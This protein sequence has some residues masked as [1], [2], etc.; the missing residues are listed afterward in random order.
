MKAILGCLLLLALATAPAMAGRNASGGMLV[1][2]N[3]SVV[4]SIG[5]DYCGETMPADC[6]EFQ[7]TIHKGPDDAAVIWALA[8][9]CWESSPGVTA[10]RFGVSGEVPQEY[11]AA[12]AP[13]GPGTVENPDATWPAPG[14]GTEVSYATPVYPSWVMKMYWFAAWG[15]TGWSLGTGAYP[16]GDMQAEFVDDS[17]PPV[18]DYC[19]AFGAVRWGSP[20]ANDCT[21]CGPPPPGACCFPDGTCQELLEDECMGAGG[22]WYGP[23]IPCD[24][25]PCVTHL[26]ACCFPDGHCEPMIYGTGQCA[27]E[28]GIGQGIDTYCDP[29]PCPPAQA[30]CFADG[31]CEMLTVD[32]CT[33]TGGHPEGEGTACQGVQCEPTAT[34][35]TTWGRIK[36]SYR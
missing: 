31:H 3:D 12:F 29:N 1:H 20:G 18:I 7:T 5:M 36:T 6:V 35:T 30:C 10:F 28:G 16:H 26:E 2:T 33:A 27:M 34:K 8:Y 32:A 13:C 11:F 9:W 23:G 17:V 24:P 19:Q 25:N 15:E 14:T 21:D 4:F 22:A